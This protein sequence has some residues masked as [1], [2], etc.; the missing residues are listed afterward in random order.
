M[1]SVSVTLVS[2]QEVFCADVAEDLTVEALKRQILPDVAFE[3]KALLH[4]QDELDDKATVVNY[5]SS[6]HACLMLLLRRPGMETAVIGPWF[7]HAGYL[8]VEHD[9]E[10]GR[11]V[12][13]LAGVCWLNAGGSFADMQGGDWRICVRV[14]RQRYISFS[15]D[16]I[17]YFNDAKVQAVGPKALHSLLEDEW[18]LLELGLFCGPGSLHVRLAGADCS[19]RGQTPKRGLYIDRLVAQPQ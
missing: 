7:G 9:A 4:G 19:Q 18:T 5:L 11:D 14:R 1:E 6:R 12:H 15:T 16:L 2:G 8:P 10:L 3:K 13:L 17:V